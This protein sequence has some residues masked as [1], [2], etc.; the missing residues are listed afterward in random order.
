MYQLEFN[1]PPATFMH[2]VCWFS[3]YLSQSQSQKRLKTWFRFTE[4]KFL[5]SLFTEYEYFTEAI[6]VYNGHLDILLMNVRS[7]RIINESEHFLKL[8]F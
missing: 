2:I 7:L 8:Q 5:I 3:L 4:N 6:N 1:I